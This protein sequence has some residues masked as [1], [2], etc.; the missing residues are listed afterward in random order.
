MKELIFKIL[1]IVTCLTGFSLAAK[2]QFKEEA[3][4]QSYNNEADSL[5][6]KDSVDRLWS[7]KEFFHGVAH[8]DS[9]L[10][11]GSMFA[12][13]TVFLGAEQFYNRQYWKI[14]V[15]YAGVGAGLGMGIHYNKLYKD[16]KKA[17]EAAY[18]LDPETTLTIDT[19]SK[20]MAT[21]MFAAAGLVYWTSLMDGVVNYK[22]DIPNQ[23][24]KA[25]IYSI[26]L[27][28]LGQ[29]YN[30]EA[31]KIPIY[32]GIMIGSYHYYSVNKKNYKRFKRIH[33]EITAENSTY[34]GYYTAERALYFRNVFRRY[35]DYSMVG[36]IGG[37]LLQVIDAN[38]F[39]YM[40][41]FE[42]NDDLSLKVTPTVIS[43]YNEY[44]AGIPAPRMSF[45]QGAFG[46]NAIGIKVGLTF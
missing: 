21:Y 33:N 2:A 9:T 17:Y 29:I 25:T 18:E 42:V 32:W 6:T 31:W 15:V 14:P 10:R 38:V 12:G 13:S 27:P 24:G 40:Q 22:K 20:D 36:I 44:A 45:G 5:A 35:R 1:L 8:H 43:P 34:D 16:S 41:D 11:I 28:G 4:N 23:A 7:F 26:L 39:A 30:H 46:D 19:H 3:F 37:Y